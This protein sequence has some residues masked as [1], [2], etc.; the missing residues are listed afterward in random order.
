MQFIVIGY[1]GTDEGALDR[2]MAV[3]EAHL[4]NFRNRVEEGTFLYG[5]ALL[6]DDGKMIGSMILCDFPSREAPHEQWL[7]QEVYVIGNVW[8][9]I[10]VYPAQIP[11]ILL[12]K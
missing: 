4:K 8:Q 9:N 6:S 11:P 2:R 5:C 7:D 1:D 12:T 3:R 10:A